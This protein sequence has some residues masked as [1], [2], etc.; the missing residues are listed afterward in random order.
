MPR[1]HDEK[2][3]EILCTQIINKEVDI[4]ETNQQGSNDEFEECVSL[5]DSER[6]EKD[7]DWMSDIRIPEFASHAL[8]QSS[9]DV[10]QYFQTR[11][12]VEVYLQ[13][14][15]EEAKASAKTAK[16]L[17]NRTLNQKHL[18]HYL[19]FVRGKGINNV[20]G[21]VYAKCWWEQHTVRDVI[22][23]NVRYEDLDVDNYGEPLI[24][25]DQVPAQRE[26]VEPVYGDIPVIDRFNY[27]IWDQRNVFT[28]NSYV[29]SLQ[30]KQ[31]VTFRS[32][33][34]LTE[35]KSM[36]RVNGY[37]NLDLLGSD[38]IEPPKKTKFA[39][40]AADKDQN[41]EPVTSS[42]ERPF[43]IYERYGKFWTVVDENKD[44]S[45]V[46]GTE[47]I[48][49]DLEGK[50]LKK[51][52][53]LEVIIT[54]AQSGHRN[55][56]IGFKLT[57]F[58]DA[59]GFPYRPCIRGLCY[60]HLT[61]DAGIGDGKYSKELQIAIDDTFNI[62]QDR[63]MLATLPTFALNKHA[64][65]DN[66]SI[67]FEPGHPMEV[68]DPSKDI[69]EFTI[70]DNIS[71]A[72][73][74]M[75]TLADKM[76]Q[77]DSIQPPSMGDSG[78]AST[79]ATAFAGAF[80][81]TGERANYK[82]LTF[83]N[84]FLSDLYWMIQQMTFM[85]AKSETG[86]ELMGEKVYNFD[87]SKDYWYK[88]LSQSIEPEYSKAAK[89]KEWATLFGYAVQLLGVHPDAVKMLNYIYSEYVK[90]MGDEYTNFASSFLD[91]KKPVTP[92]GGQGQQMLE[93]GNS[94]PMS[95]Q[96]MV[97]QSGGELDARGQANIGAF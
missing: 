18:N 8:T 95:N 4:A 21:R 59:N 39:S 48:G 71:G 67:Y 68:N 81:A 96:N 94:M 36:E 31:W 29:Y 57:P 34:T 2:V 22:G 51:A 89:R 32:E 76:Q 53:L 52:R 74:Q 5:L 75:A 79:T 41:Y 43:D 66:S 60:V 62:S 87:P 20:V 46:I 7:Y 13:D 47:K 24:Y 35:L 73:A 56:L 92:Q 26:V 65:E 72:L 93:G 86:Y 83:E 6:R 3:E 61:E 44:G 12:F 15:G 30:E 45:M 17:I 85:F 40:S 9:L 84:T 70:S 23:E 27:D 10:A 77:V 11:D 1:K 28:D 82:S 38:D 69:K 58:V 19:K 88:P 55:I 49:L 63:V 91:E 37:F 90:L 33:S 14:E 78:A 54:I 42:I 25:D 80:K 16:E 97:P 64:I 50:P